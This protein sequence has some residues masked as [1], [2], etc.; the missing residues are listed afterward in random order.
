MCNLGLHSRRTRTT[1]ASCKIDTNNQSG[2]RSDLIYSAFQ[3]FVKNTI[4]QK[5]TVLVPGSQLLKIKICREFLQSPVLDSFLLFCC[6]NLLYGSANNNCKSAFSTM[7]VSLR[8]TTGFLFKP[9]FLISKHSGIPSFYLAKACTKK[10]VL[11]H[12]AAGWKEG[13][14]KLRDDF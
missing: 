6:W 7:H 12:P 13:N 8:I 2:P 10:V 1:S 11:A 9:L 5:S 3:N 4:L 14:E